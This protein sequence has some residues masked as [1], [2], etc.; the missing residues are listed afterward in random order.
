MA[1]K[2]INTA[3]AAKQAGISRRYVQKLAQDGRIGGAVQ[4]GRDWLIPASF[5]WKPL[6]GG[7][8]PKRRK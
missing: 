8:K 1:I 2:L 5:K 6:P 7:P 3:Q 4:I